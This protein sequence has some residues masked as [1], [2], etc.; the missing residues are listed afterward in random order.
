VRIAL[1]T[2]L[3]YLSWKRFANDQKNAFVFACFILGMK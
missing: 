3:V 2:R 1:A